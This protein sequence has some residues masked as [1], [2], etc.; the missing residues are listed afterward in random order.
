MTERIT[1]IV[2]RLA[3]ADNF[4]EVAWLLNAPVEN[5]AL[6]VVDDTMREN[7][8]FQYKAGL[9][10]KV[11]RYTNDPHACKW[12]QAQAG[13][14]EYPNVPRDVWRRHE[15][16]E[17]VIEYTPAGGGR[18][19]TLRGRGKAWE[20]IDQEV[21]AE[22]KAFVGVDTSPKTIFAPAE[23]IEQAKE[24]AQNTLGLGTSGYDVM[25]IDVANMVN[26]EITNF[27]NTFGN[28]HELGVLDE[29]RVV[30][31]KQN[32][33]MAY[34]P[35]FKSLIMP[36]GKVRYKTSIGKMRANTI[37]QKEW[38][39][40]STSAPEHSIR[41]ELG[42]AVEKLYYNGNEELEAKFTGIRESILQDIG[43]GKWNMNAGDEVMLGA[44]D[45]ISY[46]ALRNNGELVAESVA[47]YMNGNPR[48][49]ANEVVGELLQ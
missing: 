15:R 48:P 7:A 44:G 8:E 9:P 31:G 30:P 25:N 29:I 33:Y 14:Y 32:F 11:V 18:V 45:K 26:E 12:C 42:H 20:Q 22:R 16:C 24:Y 5:I 37:Q 40:W 49:V 47:E 10:A 23:T 3:D 46:Y 43:G 17:C 1:G 39:F 35:G 6:S 27:Y 13:T 34:N 36:S 41:H 28:L 2:D 19:D 4:E 21:L 38:G